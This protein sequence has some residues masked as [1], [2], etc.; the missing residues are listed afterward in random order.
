M[1]RDL[2]RFET[3]LTLTDV[4]SPLNTVVVVRLAGAPSPE[5]LRGALDRAQRRHPLLRARILRAGRRYRFAAADPAPPIP[6]TTGER[7]S[8]TAW[9]AAA[10]DELAARLDAAAGPLMRCRLLA[11][12]GRGELLLTFHHAVMDAAS[13]THLAG[14]IL[15]AWGA[16]AAGEAPPAPAPLPPLPPAEDFFPPAFRS[17]RRRWHSARFLARQMA[18][19]V[20]Y[21]RADRG[22]RHPPRQR[23]FRCRI[24]SRE[25]SVAE[26]TALV[27]G[28]RRRRLTLNSV[29]TAALLRAV[30]VRLYGG[31][32]LPL[33]NLMFADLRPY[34]EPPLGEENL[35]AYFAMLRLTLP[36]DPGHDLWQASREVSDAVLAASRR[37]E[38]FTS[39]LWSAATMRAV[40][41]LGNQRM[42]TTALSY[43]GP[44]RLPPSDG[45]LRVEGLHAFV[46]S[47]PV[48]PEVAV[49][50]RLF[51]GRLVWDVLY[52]DS[53]VDRAAVRELADDTLARL[54]GACS[55]PPLPAAQNPRP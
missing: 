51:A 31:E 54:R 39:P 3:A 50:V 12:E 16:L 11:G 21:R 14:E 43:T 10:E 2:G 40:L 24:L 23:P 45:P 37:G 47:L 29:L 5:A 22:R 13:A 34:L 49:Q 25:L 36:V 55:D 20:R 30:A 32:R 19:E 42:A 27:R 28:S 48:G 4:R 9:T 8:D 33:R 53:D 41:R 46:A 52:L 17:W 26:T 38:K 35:G 44:A 18:D 1:D 15:E 6:L 7:S